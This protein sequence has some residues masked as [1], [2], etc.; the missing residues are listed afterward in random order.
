[1]AKIRKVANPIP[2]FPVD[3]LQPNIPKRRAI[4]GTAASIIAIAGF[5]KKSSGLSETTKISIGKI[6]PKLHRIKAY[7]PNLP[8]LKVII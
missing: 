1:M 5:P 4:A 2:N 7:S 8:G 3:V 6:I